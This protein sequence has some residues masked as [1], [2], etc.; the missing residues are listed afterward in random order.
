MK[1]EEAVVEPDVEIID[2]SA[3][4][5]LKKRVAKE[6]KLE[7]AGANA[8]Q[9]KKKKR[10]VAEQKVRIN[11]NAVEGH[12]AFTYESMIKRIQDE[13]KQKQGGDAHAKESFK[14]LDVHSVRAAR[15]STW[16]NFQAQ[17]D[18]LNRDPQH[19]LSYFL[20]ELGCQGNIG[21][22]GQM[23]L[24]GG[25]MPQHFTRLIRRYTE[26]FVQCKVCKSMRT[27]VERDDKTRLTF[28]R[29][30]HCQATRTVQGIQTHFKA[31]G[32]GDRRRNR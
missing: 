9:T 5:Q 24:V 15:K 12:E 29:C 6:S 16:V 28:L 23:I 19:I 30:L 32:R 26:E 3:G 7:K 25:Y 14:P 18:A 13:I 8:K 31:T 17:A 2:F 4:L 11:L 1:E 22:E 21:S 10:D 20:S 27:E